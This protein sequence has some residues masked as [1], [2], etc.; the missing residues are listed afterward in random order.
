MLGVTSASEADVNQSDPKPDFPVA[1]D[2][3]RKFL[4]GAG[5]D[6]F[7]CVMLLDTNHVVRFEGHPAALTQEILQG[8][9]KKMDEENGE[10]AP[11]A[12]PSAAESTPPA[13]SSG[14]PTPPTPPN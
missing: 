1:I 9:F 11:T 2:S 3:D 4:N 12:A 13:A 6:T 7:P 10:A 5:V 14:D 8:I